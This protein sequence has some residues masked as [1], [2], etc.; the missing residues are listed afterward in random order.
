MLKRCGQ[1]AAEPPVPR[2]WRRTNG[3]HRSHRTA[4]RLVPQPKRDARHS[5]RPLIW[6]RTG[7]AGAP[8]TA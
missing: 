5:E 3:D 4:S 1:R 6:D 2:T 8:K 7:T